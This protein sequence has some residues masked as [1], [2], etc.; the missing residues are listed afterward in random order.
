MPRRAIKTNTG[1]GNNK[2]SYNRVRR[3]KY[4]R[5]KAEAG[6]SVRAYNRK[7]PASKQA[8]AIAQRV[9]RDVESP[10]ARVQRTMELTLSRARS[11][12]NEMRLVLNGTPA[13][14]FNQVCDDYIRCDN[15]TQGTENI[16]RLCTRLSSFL[17]SINQF[18]DQILN[19]VGSWAPQMQEYQGLKNEVRQVANMAQ[20]IYEVVLSGGKAEVLC[21]A[22][23]GVFAFQASQ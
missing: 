14:Y 6:A 20:E 19:T 23:E 18:E 8:K 3:E 11:I 21:Q 16:D 2:K 1:D 9:E 5:K 15:E 7:T 22:T 13:E 10:Q 4:A 12:R 17:A